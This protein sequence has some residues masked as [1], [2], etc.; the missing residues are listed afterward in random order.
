[1]K[2]AVILVAMLAV[3]G[4]RSE[5]VGAGSPHPGQA[6]GETLVLT[7][8]QEVRAGG[9]LRLGFH[10]VLGDSRCPT[11]VVCVWAGNAEV[12]IGLALGMA[13]THP[14]VLN[15]IDHPAAVEFGGYRVTLLNLTPYPRSPL[16]IDPADYRAHLRVDAIDGSG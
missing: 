5:P 10:Q 15:T 9:I 3:A 8:G 11:D 1:M 14:F 12:Q 6:L 2:P 4:C 13:P 16:R 7:P